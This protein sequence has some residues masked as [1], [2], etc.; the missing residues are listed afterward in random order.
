MRTVLTHAARHPYGSA[1]YVID[2]DRFRQMAAGDRLRG[3]YQALSAD[4]NSLANL[5]Q[6]LPNNM[7]HSI[8]IHTL[9]RSWLWCETWCSDE[10]LAEAKTID[11]CN[12]PKTHE[13]KLQR[14]K[15]LL[16]EWTVY[17]KEIAALAARVA[18]AASSASSSDGSVGATDSA[19]GPDAAGGGSAARAFSDE[20]GDTQQAKMQQVEFVEEGT[21]KGADIG[22][23]DLARE[24]A[25]EQADALVGEHI[26]HSDAPPHTRDEL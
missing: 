21:G 13:P 6:D 22:R 8:P 15:R 17:D 11:L 7:Q 5:D 18:A 23:E 14:A 12:N 1:L 9:D 2:L 24:G 10:T 25:E 16:P 26:A 19:G 4:P 3:Q 20:A